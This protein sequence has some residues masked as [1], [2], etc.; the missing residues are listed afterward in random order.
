MQIFRLEDMIR[1]WYIG[2]FTP[3][4]YKTEMCE[5]AVKKYQAGDRECRHI[6][7]CADEV[8]LV[9]SGSIQMND[10]I[11]Y[12]GDIIVIYKNMPCIF[13]AITDSITVVFK[14]SSIKGDKYEV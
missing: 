6:H 7:K 8:T 4:V 14:S 12:D 9:L 13:K 3:A 1:G 2:N 11:L 5:V 10:H